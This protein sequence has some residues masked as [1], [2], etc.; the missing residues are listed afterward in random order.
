MTLGGQRGMMNVSGESL[1]AGRFITS[2]F[3]LRAHS[4]ESYKPRILARVARS[5]SFHS[6][7][8]VLDVSRFTGRSLSPLVM[9][10]SFQ[11]FK[12][13]TLLILTPC[14]ACTADPPWDTR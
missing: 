8:I 9:E 4:Q 14:V 10:R 3:K 2:L 13:P 11:N 5:V 6:A 1:R 12:A 7:V